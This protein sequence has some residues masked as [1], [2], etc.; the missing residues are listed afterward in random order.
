MALKKKQTDNT[1]EEIQELETRIHQLEKEL[2]T[3][4]HNLKTTTL[5]LQNARKELE[6]CHKMIYE[7]KLQLDSYRNFES[8]NRMDSYLKKINPLVDLSALFEQIT[9]STDLS[10]LIQKMNPEAFQ[11]TIELEEDHNGLEEPKNLRARTNALKKEWTMNTEEIQK[12]A[13]TIFAEKFSDAK[14]SNYYQFTPINGGYCLEAYIGF[15]DDLLYIPETYKKQAILEVKEALFL[16][17]RTLKTLVIAAPLKTIPKSFAQGCKVERVILPDTV[18]RIDTNAFQGSELRTIE[19]GT[20]LQRIGEGAFR[21]SQLMEINFPETLSLIGKYTFADT[22]L[23]SLT[24]PPLLKVVPQECFEGCSKLKEVTLNQNL[25]KIESCAFRKKILDYPDPTPAEIT[26]P[27]TVTFL[28]STESNHIFYPF[29]KQTLIKC[30]S[31]S[32]A[33]QW[34]REHGYHVNNAVN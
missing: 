17:C 4:S 26:I 18:T 27:S 33:Q 29:H 31:G 8:F 11:H 34:A 22:N 19:L 28:E 15:D 6:I 32:Y 30:Y 23:S 12:H 10:P 9:E 16:N 1:E 13:A 24:L 2:K 3:T 5:D 21:G 14:L 20:A 25:E 7:A